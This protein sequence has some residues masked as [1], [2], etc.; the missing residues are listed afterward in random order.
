MAHVRGAMPD[1]VTCP[2]CN[3]NNGARRTSCLYCGAALPVTES[4]ASIQVP[5]LRPVEEWEKGYSVILA[6]LDAAAPTTEQLAR[7]CEITRMEEPTARAVFDARAPL[8]VARVPSEG[9]A[10]L[11]MRLLGGADLGAS[12]LADAD[13]EL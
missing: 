10:G 12:I 9:E 3:R 5:T 11:V 1:V 7:L 4:S 13:L 8:P 2:S 6:P